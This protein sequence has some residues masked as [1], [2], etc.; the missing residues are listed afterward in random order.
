MHGMKEWP[1][2]LFLLEADIM[3]ASGLVF[4]KRI[5]PIFTSIGYAFGFAF[6]Y[7]FQFDYGHGQNS[8]WII[9]SGV[10]FVMIL[11]GIAVDFWSQRKGTDD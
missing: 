4:K 11:A 5:I 1:L 8:L 6:G 7:I 2:I 9:W 10:Y 3:I